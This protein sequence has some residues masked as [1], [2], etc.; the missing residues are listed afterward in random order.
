METYGLRRGTAMTI[1]AAT[2]WVIWLATVLSF[3]L[4]SDV[5]PLSMIERFRT[6]TIF[7]LTDYFA[8]NILLP[9]GALL[10]SLFV[11][12]RLDH[13]T[14]A[15]DFGDHP[16]VRTALLLLLRY[17]CPIAIVGVLLSAI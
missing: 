2:A 13:Q 15:P 10:T 16:A 17:L 6:S 4:W 8:S 12:W 11:G 7:D 9:V 1:V 3:N 14:I 5:H